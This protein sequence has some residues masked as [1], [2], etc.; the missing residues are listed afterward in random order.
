MQHRWARYFSGDRDLHRFAKLS[1]FQEL[2]NQVLEHF[3]DIKC[4]HH[5]VV[6]HFEVEGVVHNSQG[7]RWPVRVITINGRQNAS[8]ISPVAGTIQQVD[9]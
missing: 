2:R 3:K 7:A 8:K 6:R 9:I 4:S 5:N 1:L